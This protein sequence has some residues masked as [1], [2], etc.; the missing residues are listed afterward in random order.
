MTDFEGDL[1]RALRRREPPR[2]LTPAIIARVGA[3]V[4]A[5]VRPAGVS[6]RAVLAAAAVLLVMVTGIDQG[7]RA[8]RQLM[9]AMEL[10]A[11][12]LGVAQQKVNELSRRRIGRD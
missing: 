5:R 7:L 8:K 12:K 4:G 10:T 9:F 2:D 11:Q 6:W 3:R 1:Q